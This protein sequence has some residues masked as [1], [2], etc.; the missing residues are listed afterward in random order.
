MENKLWYRRIGYH[1]I[2]PYARSSARITSL[3]TGMYTARQEDTY[4]LDHNPFDAR[5]LVDT[6]LKATTNEDGYGYML[7]PLA[8][9]I[10]RVSSIPMPEE[11]EKMQKTAELYG[12]CRFLHL[13]GIGKYVYVPFQEIFCT[14]FMIFQKAFIVCHWSIPQ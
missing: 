8:E 7:N 3:N 10:F 13:F 14:P 5:W 12:Y 2:K 9:A 6:A 4:L 1:I 11:T